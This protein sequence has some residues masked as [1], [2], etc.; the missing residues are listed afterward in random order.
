MQSIET[1]AAAADTLVQLQRH[2]ESKSS[3]SNESVTVKISPVQNKRKAVAK[4]SKPKKTNMQNID[5]MDMNSLAG[6]DTST[7]SLHSVQIFI[8]EGEF[9]DNNIKIS[10]K[11]SKDIEL[12]R[13]VNKMCHFIN[14][15]NLDDYTALLDS[16][17]PNCP[18][19]VGVA[20][21]KQKHNLRDYFKNLANTHPDV[22]IVPDSVSLVE[23]NVISAVIVFSG[24]RTQGTSLEYMQKCLGNKSLVDCMN[25]SLKSDEEIAALRKLEEDLYQGRGAKKTAIGE[26]TLFLA[27][28]VC[29]DDD[30]ELIG[31]AQQDYLETCSNVS[32]LTSGSLNEIENSGFYTRK[33]INA[34]CK[35]TVTNF[36]LI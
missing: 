29:D 28:D 25:L 18:I 35:W 21:H 5:M 26:L 10:P 8:S 19:N 15:F 33:I 24:T 34:S 16:A 36:T 7:C 27:P 31:D 12:A 14:T 9:L 3:D 22:L 11:Y 13:V 6:T 32:T 2:N 17:A 30:N 4:V 1:L 23:S 20:P